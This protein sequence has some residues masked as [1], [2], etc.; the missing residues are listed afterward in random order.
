MIG[1]QVLWQPAPKQ[2]QLG[3]NDLQVWQTSLNQPAA[4]LEIF[5]RTLAPDE[6]SRAN[7]FKAANDRQHFIVAHFFLRT[8]LASFLQM[9]PEEL[10]FQ[11]GPQGKPF[12]TNLARDKR[13]Y[14][15]L[16][17]SNNLA[18]F[19]INRKSEVGVDVEYVQRE[20]DTEQIAARFFSPMEVRCLNTLSTEMRREGFFRCW[21]RKEA[22]IKATGKGLSFTARSVR[23]IC[24]ANWAVRYS[25]DQGRYRR[26]P[27]L[28]SV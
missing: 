1:D 27:E 11:N 17:H 26:A 8:I 4:L 6:R 13:T 5:Q 19:A 24:W 7:R 25:G 2:L 18:L 14:F 3:E 28:C 12:L 21:T 23:G 15:N 20:V 16:S 10:R 9:K 22:Y